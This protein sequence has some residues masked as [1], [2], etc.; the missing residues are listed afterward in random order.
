[1]SGA[2]RGQHPI[3]GAGAGSSARHA[4]DACLLSSE[5]EE[6]GRLLDP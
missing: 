6:V 1:M 2:N 4:L 5:E 3:P